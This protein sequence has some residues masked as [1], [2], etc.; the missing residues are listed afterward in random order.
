MMALFYRADFPYRAKSVTPLSW[1]NKLAY[2]TPLTT[3]CSKKA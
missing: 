3:N 2:A 1:A